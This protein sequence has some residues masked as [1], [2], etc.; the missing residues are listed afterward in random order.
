MVQKLSWT[1]PL[2]YHLSYYPSINTTDVLQQADLR[3][4]IGSCKF[5]KVFKNTV[6]PGNNTLPD[7]GVVLMD[8]WFLKE[9]TLTYIL[10]YLC[11]PTKLIM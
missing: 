8:H 10:F 4:R 5:F 11:D 9:N 7:R 1:M 3:I 2:P 6:Q